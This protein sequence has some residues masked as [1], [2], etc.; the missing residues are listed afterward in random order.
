MPKKPQKLLKL[1]LGCGSTKLPGYVNIDVEKDCK[2]DLVCNFVGEPLPYGNNTVDEIV[3]FHCIEHLRKNSH[4]LLLLEL[5]RVLKPQGELYVSYPE[6]EQCFQNWKSN[7]K[8][9]R[10]FWEATMFGRQ[11]YPSDFHVCAMYTPDFEDLLQQCGFHNIFSCPE[12]GEPWNTVVN[13]TKGAAAVGYE[14]LL[15][16]DMKKTKFKRVS[17]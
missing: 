4:K 6:F 3:F 13:C 15:K 1:N 9:K 14:D 11:A 16:K 8:G 5:W 12:A 7:Y 17:L 10:D 2:P